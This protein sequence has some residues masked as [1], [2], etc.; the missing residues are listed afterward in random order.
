[1][2]IIKERRELRSFCFE[3]K[4][5]KTAFVFLL[6]LAFCSCKQQAADLSEDEVYSL[7][8]QIIRDDS[9]YPMRIC[10]KTEMTNPDGEWS[11]EFSKE[12]HRFIAQQQKRFSG[13]RFRPGKLKWHRMHDTALLDCLIDTSC[14][15]G[16]IYHISFPLISADRKKVLFQLEDDCNC[17]LGSSGGYYL[18]VFENGKWRKAKTYRQWISERNMP[19]NDHTTNLTVHAN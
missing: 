4:M 17:L 8:N 5:R 3:N 9:L 13:F 14:T 12:D 10:C 16:F 1:M 6:L 2:N 11:S 18:Y 15:E 7:L 19:F